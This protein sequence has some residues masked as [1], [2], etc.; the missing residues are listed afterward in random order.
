MI[1]SWMLYTA[2]VGALMTIAAL[3]LDRALTARG[4]ATRGVWT[5][6]IALSLLVPAV[7]AI[8][9]E[10]FR[11]APTSQVLPFTITVAA[12]DAMVINGGSLNRAQ[13]INRALIALWLG[14]SVLLFFR[15]TRAARTL[16]RMRQ[17][18]RQDEV[19]GVTVHLSSN[20]GPAVVGLGPMHV[21]LPEWILAL[22]APHR[23]L[24]LKHEQEHREA[25][26]PYLLFGSALSVALMPWNP[27]LW[28]QS[29]RLR[30]AIEMDC[31]A[32]VLRAH[33][34]P[35]RYGLLMLTIAQRRSVAPTLF[36]PMLSEPTTHLERRIVA[37]RASTHRFNR[38]TTYGAMAFSAAVLVLAG[39]LR[40]ASAKV[41]GPIEVP[42]P[43]ATYARVTQ[44]GNPG[45]RY[46]DML[47]QA[48]IE[49]TVIAEFSTDASGVPD[50]STLKVVASSHDLFA[51]SVRGVLPR[52]HLAPSTTL[53]IPFMFVMAN[54]SG[55]ALT[56]IPPNAVVIT[57]I[58]VT[59]TT[60]PTIRAPE[61][62]VEESGVRKA[63]A[64]VV[65][66]LVDG[67]RDSVATAA[68]RRANS[69]GETPV[70][71]EVPVARSA[72]TR[73]TRVDANQTFFEF[74]IEKPVTPIPGNPAPRY[75]DMLRSANVEGTVLAQ[76]VVDTLGHAD[77]STFKVLKSTHDLFTEAVQKSLPNMLFRPAEIGGKKVK[78][79]LQMPFEF[80][81]TK[82]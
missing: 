30:L 38:I 64:V 52:W 65:T 5:A 80:S 46:P 44:Q 36:A 13:I 48:E 9:R 18:W 19:D 68:V 24:V 15:L 45:P 71:R 53:R 69:A 81:L 42:V 72:G 74:Q 67:T 61:P 51:M 66:A 6:A 29:E 60:A 3:A 23:A 7:D 73:P 35:E 55:Q 75:P 43:A 25:R 22:D 14:G 58:P 63:N 37:M 2:A 20:V 10:W 54:K 47:R 27:A 56:S 16:H 32:R 57:G 26:D 62:R 39:S 59:A 40:S 41:R 12:P 11:R 70:S 28:I 82:G 8:P 76:F 77:M 79:L 31:D 21:V 50:M 78:Q 49:G 1:A 4:R 34:T 33:P 17:Q